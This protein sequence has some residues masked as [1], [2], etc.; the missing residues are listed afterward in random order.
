MPPFQKQKSNRLAAAAVL[1]AVAGLAAFLLRADPADTPLAGLGGP[2]ASSP[3]PAPAAPSVRA[4]PA[5]PEA[6]PEERG[7]LRRLKVI[8]PP[9]P[10]QPPR[11]VRNA[12]VVGEETAVASAR[13]AAMGGVGSGSFSLAAS[14]GGGFNASATVGAPG[15]PGDPSANAPAASGFG[16]PPAAA[17]NAGRGGV[18]PP[19]G[20][21][22]GA[23]DAADDAQAEGSAIFSASS[24]ASRLVKSARNPLKGNFLADVPYTP[25]AIAA[26]LR[27]QIA[28]E[29]EV[30]DSVRGALDAL[31]P[32]A[33]P[34]AREEAAAAILNAAGQPSS[35]EDVQQAVAKA[36]GPPFPPAPPAAVEAAIEQFTSNL[37]TKRQMDAQVEENLR[38]MKAERRPNAPPPKGAVDAYLKYRDAFDR[39][40]KENGLAPSQVVPFP[41]I[42]SSLGRNTGKKPLEATLMGI[43]RSPKYKPAQRLQA[44]RD[45]TA[46]NG[47]IA[48]GELGGRKWNEL[49]GSYMGAIGITQFLPTSFAAYGRSMKGGPRDPWDFRDAVLSTGNYLE[50]HGSRKDYNRSILSYNHSTKYQQDILQYGANVAPG[51]EAVK[52]ELPKP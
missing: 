39:V 52:K 38:D 17:G 8:E 51:I 5:A 12:A 50:R 19:P 36:S 47:L 48:R 45:I 31:G 35:P 26:A 28:K 44:S 10:G 24:E 1:L 34:E 3:E 20:R 41:A 27:K 43:V 18:R 4:E 32:T 40:Q 11:E 2:D 9:M 15:V 42:E 13:P 6:L 46:T 21:A 7:Y 25:K 29:Q 30:D 37:P 22:P 23:G 33:A 49:Y 14:G 16:P